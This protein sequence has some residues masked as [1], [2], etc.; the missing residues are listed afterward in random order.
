M[1]LN[2]FFLKETDKWPSTLF[3]GSWSY[4]ERIGHYA[5]T[6]QVVFTARRL[7]KCLLV[8]HNQVRKGQ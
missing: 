4:N 1:H 2:F 8:Q 3:N 5:L 7:E 6:L